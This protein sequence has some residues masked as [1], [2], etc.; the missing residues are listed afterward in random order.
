MAITWAASADKHGIDREDALH[1]IANAVYVETEFDEPRPPEP[2][3][4]GPPG[5]APGGMRLPMGPPPRRDFYQIPDGPIE[6]ML[7][8]ADAYAAQHKD[9]YFNVLDV[10]DQVKRRAAG[11]GRT[12][13]IDRRINSLRQEEEK[14][15]AEAIRRFANVSRLSSQGSEVAQRKRCRA[16]AARN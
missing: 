7:A 3:Q 12:E 10:Y 6:A 13:E 5:N 1:A 11:S 8:A 4:F 15:V 14:A 2:G 9:D 16:T